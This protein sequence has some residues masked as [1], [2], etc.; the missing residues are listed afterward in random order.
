MARVLL[1]TGPGGSGK[2]AISELLEEKHGWI[3]VDGDREDTEFFPN[4]GQWLPENTEALSKAHDKII[5][6]A[7]EKFALGGN[8]V[9]DYIIFGRYVEF[10]EKLRKEF[11][12]SFEVRVLWPTK[13]E[14][15]TRDLERECW[16]T[17]EKRISEVMAEF[18]SIKKEI[19]PTNYIDT[20]TQSPEETISTYFL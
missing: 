2:T 10:I 15:V 13:Q 20:T 18:E 7:K 1:I 19:G 4:N 6:I 3:R 12:D 17:G 8:V 5:R 11:G 16:T 14:T 9:I